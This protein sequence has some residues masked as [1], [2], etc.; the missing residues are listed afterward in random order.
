MDK[1]IKELE[2]IG[3][4][5]QDAMVRFLDDEEFYLECYENVIND[6]NFDG[7]KRALENHDAQQGFTCAHTL[8]GLVANLGLKS[9]VRLLEEIVEPL[10]E[11]KVENLIEKYDALMKE[12][13]IYIAIISKI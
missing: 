6:A 7:L 3:C 12:R 13:E 5:I 4:D 1:R 10:R 9:L 2:K 8:K 11:G